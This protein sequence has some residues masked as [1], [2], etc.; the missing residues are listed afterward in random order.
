MKRL[1]KIILL[2]ATGSIGKSTIELLRF[3]KNKFKLIG[4]SANTNVKKL[5]KIVDEFKV[6]HVA[7]SNLIASKKMILIKNF[8]SVK[9][10]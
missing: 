5:K 1:K 2:G 3:N 4:V 10:V 6:K 8:L 9:K 7:I